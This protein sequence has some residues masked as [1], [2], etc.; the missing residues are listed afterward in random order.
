MPGYLLNITVQQAGEAALSDVHLVTRQAMLTVCWSRTS[1]WRLLLP[2]L[3]MRKCIGRSWWILATHM[4]TDLRESLSPAHT[5]E[6]KG[7]APVLAG[8]LESQDPPTCPATEGKGFFH[9]H[10][11]CWSLPFCDN[12]IYLFFVVNFWLLWV[13]V[14]LSGLSLETR[15]ATLRCGMKASHCSG[16]SCCRA[17]ALGCKGF[18]SCS[19]HTGLVAE[20]PGLQSCGAWA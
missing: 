1:L 13:F 11:I 6:R 4:H 14:A 10:M 18:S 20:A 19:Q 17:Q 8:L 12:F 9:S 5:H 2:I 15:G 7:C 3:N 16:L